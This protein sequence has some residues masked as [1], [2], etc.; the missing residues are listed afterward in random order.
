VKSSRI[1][2]PVSYDDGNKISAAFGAQIQTNIL[3]N[4]RGVIAY[5]ERGFREDMDKYLRKLL[6]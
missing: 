1:S 5:K 3:I 6:E 2:F 4:R